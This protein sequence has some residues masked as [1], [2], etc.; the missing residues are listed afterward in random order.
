MKNFWLPIFITLLLIALIAFAIYVTK[1]GF[2][3]LALV[4]LN[5]ILLYLK[6]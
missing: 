1:S 6:K 4:F 3:L 5:D 2:P